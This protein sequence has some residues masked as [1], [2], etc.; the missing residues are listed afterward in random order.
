MR[1]VMFF[2]VFQTVFFLLF[3]ISFPEDSL[4]VSKKMIVSYS[5]LT[6]VTL[7]IT[8]SPLLFSGVTI[9]PIKNTRSPQ[10]APGMLLFLI[11]AVG[12]VVTGFVILIKKYIRYV[13]RP[14]VRSQI[15]LLFTGVLIMFFLMIVFNLVL[16]V[17]FKVSNFVYLGT[18]YV[19]PFVG[20]TTYA[21][22]AKKLFDLKLILTELAV[23]L[24]MIALAVQTLLS[25]TTEKVLLNAI[26]FGL[27]TYGGY[28]L[29]KSVKEEI[30]R[31][32]QIQ[33]LAKDLEA[34]NEHLKE[35]DKLKDD[36]LSMAS[37]ELNTPIAAIKGYLSMILVEGLGGK[38]PSKART[39]LE[40]VYTSSE[41]LANMVK[42]LLN[43][44]RIES[45][46][47]H[48]IWEQK[49]L[50][51]VIN[52]AVTEVMSKARE[53]HHTL[54]FEATKRKMPLTW[55][56][57]T[58]ITEVLINILGNSIK[59]TPEGGKITVKAVN[60]DEKIVVSVKDN[61]KGIPKDRQK[62]VFEKFTQV[63]VLKD[64]VKGTGLGMY[65]AKRFIELHK[66]KIWFH[67]DGEGEGT[68]FFFSLPILKSKP[69]DPHKGEDAVLH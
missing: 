6:A 8:M 26:L 9:D 1:L 61:G 58:R 24:V 44:S 19:L 66:G 46:R 54:E 64:E 12:S 50:E 55:F 67:S 23:I 10:V 33:K 49:P 16:P 15:R 13:H 20:F 14:A 25:P 36:F 4:P 45:N 28:L 63:D 34:A 22:I 38:I 17:F 41:R 5:V 62:F 51:D 56:D 3:A 2:A 11:T 31:R 43:V 69:F 42:D 52:Q 59:Y 37:H 57:I 39:Y 68:T 48:I 40:S 7:L 21:I 30:R 35:V 32:E 18:Y 53:A 65:I 29:L 60:D 27:V 47:I